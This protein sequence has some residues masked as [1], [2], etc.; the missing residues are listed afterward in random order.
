MSVHE[1]SPSGRK[2]EVN[3]STEVIGNYPYSNLS[4]SGAARALA[5]RIERH[6]REEAEAASAEM[7]LPDALEVPD[8]EAA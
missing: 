8:V 4:V 2:Q 6:Q 7:E 5:A 1:V 3:S